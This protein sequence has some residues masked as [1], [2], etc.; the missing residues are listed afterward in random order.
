MVKLIETCRIGGIMTQNPLT[1]RPDTT[2]VQ[3]GRLFEIHACNVFPVINDRG[4][5]GAS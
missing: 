1:V 2:I 3:L 5:C 4:G